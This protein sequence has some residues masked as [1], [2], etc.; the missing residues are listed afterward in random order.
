MILSCMAAIIIYL[1]V[2]NIHKICL[3]LSDGQ[4][5]SKRKKNYPDPMEVVKKY[6]ADALR[7]VCLLLISYETNILDCK[8]NCRYSVTQSFS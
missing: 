2:S 4:K 7:Y 1:C 8:K 3:C 5:M 6:G